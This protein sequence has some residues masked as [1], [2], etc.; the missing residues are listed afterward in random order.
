MTVGEITWFVL[1]LPG[2]H[3]G[4]G[5][6]CHHWCAYHHCTSLYH[7]LRRSGGLTPPVAI[8]A[9]VAASIAG[10]DAMKTAWTSM[11]LGVVLIFVPFFFVLQPALVMQG[12]VMEIV[13][14]TAV[15]MAG[16]FIR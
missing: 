6:G 12:N 13:Y 7:L 4:S 11:R 15:A 9:F 16:I 10:A 1:S 8:N 3:H 2:R 5:G 14:H